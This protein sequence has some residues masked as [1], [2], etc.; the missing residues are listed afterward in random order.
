MTN[1]RN[2]ILEEIL[3]TEG[4]DA[5]MIACTLTDEQLGEEFD[6]SYGIE[7]GAPFTAWTENRVYFPVCYDG[8][9]WVGSAPR[10]PCDEATT[11]QGS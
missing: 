11:H 8:S 4:P 10:H 7:R 3:D 9:E 5:K 1:W 6:A 2:M